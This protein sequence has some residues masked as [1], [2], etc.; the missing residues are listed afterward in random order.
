MFSISK[1]T[2]P[3]PGN[4]IDLTLEQTINA[5]VASPGTGIASMTNPISARQLWA[6]S[7]FLGKTIIS[8][9]NED[10]NL[11]KKEDIIES[12]KVSI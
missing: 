8:Y 11:T 9:L 12:L 4:P 3:F 2:K 1:T 5:G 6:E 7:H 10:L